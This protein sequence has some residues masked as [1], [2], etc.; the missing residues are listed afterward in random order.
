MLTLIFLI[1]FPFAIWNAWRTIQTAKASASWPTT[2]G[3]ITVSETVKR[4]FRPQP[5]VSYS[6]AVDGK[7]YTGRRISFAA[8]VPPK[9]TP[10]VLARYP[11]GQTVTVQYAPDK[12][13]ESVLE[14]GSNRNV[15]RAIPHSARLL[16]HP[17]D[18][19]CGAVSPARDGSAAGC[20]TLI[21]H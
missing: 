16:H 15:D 7:P 1:F 14:P 4:M 19:E 2:T 5:R 10:S 17:R 11:V 21:P 8:A 3:T 12:P 13:S 20:A 6:Y 9:E 18:R